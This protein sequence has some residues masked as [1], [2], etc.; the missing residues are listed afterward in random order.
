[1]ISC[2]LSSLYIEQYNYQEAHKILTGMDK[3]VLKLEETTHNPNSK[4]SRQD[5]LELNIV[6][7]KV[8]FILISKMYSNFILI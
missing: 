7:L 4:L 1:M 2:I 8:T 6:K 5:Q 3:T